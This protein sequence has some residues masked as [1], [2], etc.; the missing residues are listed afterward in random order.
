MAVQYEVKPSLVVLLSR[1]ERKLGRKVRAA[2]L[3][4]DMNMDEKNVASLMY[5][6]RKSDLR[7]D[8]AMRIINFF[9]SVGVPAVQA[10]LYPVPADET[11]LDLPV[12]LPPLP[13]PAP[14][15]PPVIERSAPVAH[16]PSRLRKR[17]RREKYL[18]RKARLAARQEA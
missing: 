6:K 9:N 15:A 8:T 16:R 4:R 3:A 18:R 11:D 2:E 1:Y 14:L 12:V 7:R 17:D 5:G 10:D 13:A